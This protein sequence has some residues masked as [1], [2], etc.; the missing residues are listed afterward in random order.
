LRWDLP[1]CQA[2]TYPAS[3]GPQGVAFDG[4]S[5]WISNTISDTVSELIP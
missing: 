1:Q 4:T 5:I 3:D 2:A